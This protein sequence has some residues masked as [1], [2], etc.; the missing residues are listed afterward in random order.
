MIEINLLP[1]H[2]RRSVGTPLGR[3]LIIY[4]GVALWMG[5]IYLNVSR[6]YD[7]K[8]AEK[9]LADLQRDVSNLRPVEKKVKEIEEK[10]SGIKARVDALETLYR[11]RMVWAK[12]LYDLK[13]IVQ[14]QGYEKI[15]DDLEYIWLTKLSVEEKRGAPMGGEKTTELI[16][17][18]YAS[19]SGREST[20]KTADMIRKLMDDMVRYRPEEEDKERKA[21]LEHVRKSKKDR[22]SRDAEDK[23]SEEKKTDESIKDFSAPQ[24]K[25]D[26]APEGEGNEP[27]EGKK[28]ISA[29]LAKKQEVKATEILEEHLKTES[30][31]LA[32]KPFFHFFTGRSSSYKWVDSGLDTGEAAKRLELV[33]PK[34]MEFEIRLDIK[35]PVKPEKK[36]RLGR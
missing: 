19:A 5:L 2:M 22:E 24:K 31:D 32:K 23:A 26:A 20:R 17:E 4:V 9:T 12:I 7:I 10:I 6:F 25:D 30:G 16:L 14:Q 13:K 36:G 1:E 15:N 27:E 8:N 18:G 28:R 34:A 3:Q 35:P 21:A 29:L 33:P 11:Q